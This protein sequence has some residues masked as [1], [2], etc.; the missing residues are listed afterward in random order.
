MSSEPRVEIFE[1]YFDF[2]SLGSK[3]ELSS[4]ANLNRIIMEIREIFP[5]AVFDDKL[6]QPYGTGMSTTAQD[7]DL[8]LN[9]K[10]I[11]LYYQAVRNLGS[12]S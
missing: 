12:Q 4:L 9:C 7:K 1:N 11:Y 6:V 8:E 2:S 3:I 5:Q 10:L